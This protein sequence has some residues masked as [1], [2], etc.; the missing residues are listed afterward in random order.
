MRTSLSKSDLKRQSKRHS[1]ISNHSTTE[2]PADR[3]CDTDLLNRS[4]TLNSSDD[5][6]TK[7]KYSIKIDW[8]E[9][10]INDFDAESVCHGYCRIPFKKWKCEDY[11][12]QGFELLYTYGTAKILFSPSKKKKPVKVILSSTALDQIGLDALK[13][14]ELA[15][16]DGAI[17]RRIDIALDCRSDLLDLDTIG[18]AIRN[19]QA[20]HRF[21]RIT[22][23]QDL[24]SKL[25][26]I[27]DSW[28]FGSSKGKRMIVIYDKRLERIDRGKDDPNHWVR[29]E[30]RWKSSTAKIVAKTILRL[31]RLDAG[32]LL[33][34]IDF[35]ENN[36]SE[37]E[38]RTRCAWWSEFVGQCEPVATGEKRNPATIKKKVEWVRDQICTTIAQVYVS[39]GMEFIKNVIRRGIQKT[40]REEWGRLF[41]VQMTEDYHTKLLSYGVTA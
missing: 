6:E 11:T 36:H 27:T 3:G 38:K 21:R 19:G 14:I 16:R 28:T 33:G 7:P 25:E 12:I 22:P 17:F 39:E 23:R 30:G 41:G 35:R 13:I 34:I 24:N 2:V 37:I 8:L 15:D 29:I 18:E 40:D 26:K 9:F 5:S 1:V 4:N 10:T 20:I 31:G 32:Y